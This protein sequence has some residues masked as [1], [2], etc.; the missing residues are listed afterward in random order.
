MPVDVNQAIDFEFTV[1]VTLGTG[2][3]RWCGSRRVI[4][5]AADGAELANETESTTLRR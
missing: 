3:R 2:L 4:L 5:R 1:R